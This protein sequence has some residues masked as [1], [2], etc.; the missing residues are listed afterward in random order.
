[1]HQGYTVRVGEGISFDCLVVD[2]V[3]VKPGDDVVIQVG[4]YQDCGCVQ[5]SCQLPDSAAS[6]TSQPADAGDQ[7]RRGPRPGTPSQPAEILRVMTLVDKGKAHENEVRASGML[8]TAQR[9]VSEHNL[10]MKMLNCHYSFDKSVAIFQFVADGRVDFRDLVRDLS[11]ALHTRVELRQIGVR[12][13][14]GL[15]GGLGP[16]G[17]AFCCATFLHR[18]ESVNVKMAKVQ[19]LSLNPSSVSGGCGRLKCCLRY[20]VEGYRE[21]F[22]DLPRPG[23]RCETPGGPGRVLDCNALTRRVRVRLD[24]DDGQIC[25]YTVDQVILQPKGGKAARSS[26]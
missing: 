14:A 10:K 7:K 22:R 24:R 17:R 26:E 2:G 3:H 9:K 25:D 20:E 23:T 4:S 8:R 19:R 12:D 13:E 6:P 18:F 5:R 1:M 11:G 21:M 16:C 15:V